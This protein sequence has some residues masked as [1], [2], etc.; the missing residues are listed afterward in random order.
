M[1]VRMYVIDLSAEE[2]VLTCYYV[3]LTGTREVEI[4]NG[5][6]LTQCTV[7]HIYVY[8]NCFKQFHISPPL[9]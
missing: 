1:L 4:S 6:A 2:L 7:K 3:T 5:F 9:R 8:S